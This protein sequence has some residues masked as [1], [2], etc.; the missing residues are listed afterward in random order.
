MDLTIK[1]SGFEEPG[2]ETLQDVGG[3]QD[4][5]VGG[6]Q[7]VHFLQKLHKKLNTIPSK[8][9]SK[10]VVKSVLVLPRQSISSMKTMQGACLFAAKN[11]SRTRAG[12]TP[13]AMNFSW[14]FDPRTVMSGIPAS[15][16]IARGKRP[17]PD[18]GGP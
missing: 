15:L 2:V 6:V 16:A 12:P 3:R 10:D 8:E 1:S 4:D 18:P 17:F 11:K 9:D 13:P 7:P 14:N 5:D